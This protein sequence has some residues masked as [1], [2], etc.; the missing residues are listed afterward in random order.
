[1][2]PPRVIF[3]NRVYRPS[4]AATA[5]LL[6]DLAEGLAERGWRVSVIAA[7]ADSGMVNG[8]DVHRTG[9]GE[10]HGG[11]WSRAINYARFLTGARRALANLADRDDVVVLMTDPPLLAAAATGVSRRRGARVLHWIQDIYPEIVPQHAGRWAAGPLWPLQWARNRAWRAAERCVP[12][13]GDMRLTVEARAVPASRVSVRPNWAPRELDT[14]ATETEISAQREEWGVTG[15][16][17]AA[18]SGNL[19][20]V[21][22]FA[23]ILE[24]AARLRTDDG[25]VFLFIGEGARFEEVRAE[26]QVRGL[27]N[28][29][30]LPPQPRGRLAATLAAAD[31]HFVT[32]LPGFERL[33][34]PSKLA[35]AL[36]VGRPMLFVGPVSGEIPTRLAAEKCGAAF[37][38]GAGAAL[39]DTLRHWRDEPAEPAAL[40]R[41][42]RRCY[43]SHFT[44]PAA[45]AAWEEL[46]RSPS[47]PR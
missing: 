8:V 28:V 27:T 41:G 21:H 22:E 9:P 30:F 10:R 6:A 11:L 13:S 15:K 14:P 46:L 31:A 34:S 35:G 25:F 32:L 7:V 42:A 5:Q 12:V 2:N 16:F 19:G 45:L 23:T 17:V 43:E 36:A 40:G 37:A 44:F 4:E 26:T 39:A 1:M 33:V 38:P 18:Y 3:V 47:S 20:R 24:A 29:R